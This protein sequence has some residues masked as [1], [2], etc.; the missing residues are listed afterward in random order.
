MISEKYNLIN[1]KHKYRCKTV[2]V[3]INSYTH[4]IEKGKYRYLYVLQNTHIT[5][6]QWMSQIHNSDQ[7]EKRL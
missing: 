6:H 4:Y 3:L 2:D 5:K 7:N 1:F